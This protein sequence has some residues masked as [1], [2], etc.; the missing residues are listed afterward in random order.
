MSYFTPDQINQFFPVAGIWVYPGGVTVDRSCN[1]VFNRASY[2]HVRGKVEM[3]S[4]RSLSN[5]ALLVRSTNVKFR[6]LLT[7]TYGANYPMSGKLAKKHLNHF[8]VASKRAFGA[9]DYIWVLEFQERGAV[10]FHIASTLPPPG[11]LEREEF[12]RLWQRISTPESWM[13]CQLDIVGRRLVQGQTLLTDRAVLDVHMHPNAWEKVRK[14]DSL[15]RY[16]AKY[17]TKIRQKEVPGWYS[18]VGRFWGASRDVRMPAGEYFHGGDADVRE[19][20]KEQGRDVASWRVLPK[21]IFF[22]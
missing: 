3:V 15:H 4:R 14:G 1:L 8:L 20:A 22:G 21:I 13:Y 17:S 7:L 10:H 5:L 16:F 11:E 19:L 6:S 12:A 18:D 9:Y 2:S